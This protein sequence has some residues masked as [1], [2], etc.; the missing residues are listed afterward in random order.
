MFLY[1]SEDKNMTK[2]R[3]ISNKMANIPQNAKD[4][5]EEAKEKIDRS[6]LQPRLFDRIVAER[7]FISTYLWAKDSSIED[8][9]YKLD[10]RT[11]DK[12]LREFVKR[13][14]YL[15]GILSSVISLD[16]NRGWSLIGEERQVKKYTDILH[17]F[18]V[19]VGLN[20]WRAGMSV[21]SESYYSADIGA[22]I[23]V[24]REGE[25]NIG[26]LNAF[27]FLDPACCKITLDKEKP[28]IYKPEITGPTKVSTE[29]PFYPQ[30]YFRI[31][32]MPSTSE[33][34][35]GIGYC[36]ISRCLELAR[37]LIAVMDHDKERLG[38]K[39]PKGLLLLQGITESD[40][41]QSLE[42][43][44]ANQVSE[45]ERTRYDGIQILTS[46]GITNVDAK[47]VALSQLPEF[48]NHKE[49]TDMMIYGYALNFG[50]D[51]REFWPVSSGTFGTAA[52]ATSQHKKATGKGGLDFILSFQEQL[53]NEL[54]ET[55]Q[56]Q[57]DQRDTEGEMEEQ[58]ILQEKLT[59]ISTMANLKDINNF[60]MLSREETRYLLAEAGLIPKDWTASNENV[61][62]TDIEDEEVQRWLSKPAV[63]DHLK[64]SDERIMRYRYP[65]N[66]FEILIL[67][68][69]FSLSNVR[70]NALNS[71]TLIEEI[72]QT[73]KLLETSNKIT[74]PEMTFNM[75]S[76][77][78]DVHVPETAV[79]VNPAIT[80]NPTPVNITTETQKPEVTVFNLPEQKKTRKKRSNII[81]DKNTKEMIAVETEETIE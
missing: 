76:P 43:R 15:N 5:I 7:F 25:N 10:T 41:I 53:Q 71:T 72:R 45:L 4:I 47:L 61:E 68:K 30:D 18:D 35:S 80:V 54:P 78:I 9:G 46:N 51:P 29:I 63:Q 38:T 62:T 42:A 31:V 26:P 39:A 64:L 44:K 60:P 34:L 40:W 56:F 13:E 36:A 70:Q 8:P 79:T 21:I 33:K 22:L 73:R 2:S 37:L 66:R 67:N 49:F 1:S 69:Q 3:N 52:E 74:L 27:H 12:W 55:L 6:S 65:E 11:R 50:Y 16:K 48:F 81:R 77:T 75:P 20:G 32:S 17:D 19:A 59:T 58:K 14:P 24:E 57:F 23:E 28:L